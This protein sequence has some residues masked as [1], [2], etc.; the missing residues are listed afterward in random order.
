MLLKKFS[1]RGD[2]L[3]E[4]V[5]AF[6]IFSLVV[7]ITVNAMNAGISNA[8]ASL[9]LSQASNEIEIQA[10]ALRFIHNSYVD[11]DEFQNEDKS[12]YVS[13][14]NEIIRHA[15]DSTSDIPVITG[16]PSCDS[17][18]STYSSD[19]ANIYNAKAF[20][21]NN[22]HIGVSTDSSSPNYYKNSI[23]S[24]QE[25]DGIFIPA[26]LYPRIIYTSST[27]NSDEDTDSRLLDTT[28]FNEIRTV[29]GLWVTTVPEQSSGEEFPQYYDFYINACWYAPGKTRA[30][31]IGTVVRLYNP[32]A[33]LP[34]GDS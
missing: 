2:T 28:T 6:V 13:L 16:K 33:I 5:F 29:E 18:Y 14:W 26:V 25:G 8:E 34:V 17:F 11:D 32:M 24:A 31:T 19:T 3:I 12:A 9:E 4:V 23:K 27:D 22:R 10:E 7:I 1:S 20:V 30:T 15:V 21:I